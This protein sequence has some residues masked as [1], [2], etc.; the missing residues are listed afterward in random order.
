[1][2]NTN[3]NKQLRILQHQQQVHKG[4]LSHTPTG[5]PWVFGA[6]CD[7]WAKLGPLRM[8]RINVHKKLHVMGGLPSWWFVISYCYE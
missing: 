5:L 3:I 8:D 6:S 2:L 1:M 7:S 4:A